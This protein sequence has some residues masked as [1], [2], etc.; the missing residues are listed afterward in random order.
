M[1]KAD[2]LQKLIIKANSFGSEKAR[3]PSLK[4]IYNL[5][6]EKGID[7]SIN[8][9]VNVVEY[10]TRGCR[11]VNSRHDGKRGYRLTIPVKKGELNNNGTY[12]IELDSS[13]SYYSWN[14]RQYAKEIVEI[15]KLRE[16]EK[17]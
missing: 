7:C 11:Y 2:T 14:S 1:K 8:E 6:I 17:I 5:L 9:T 15:I 13:D 12:E 3:M 16:N 4:A 10:R